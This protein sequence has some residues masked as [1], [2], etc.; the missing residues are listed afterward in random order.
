MM[1]TRFDVYLLGD[2]QPGLA[3]SQVIRNLAQV[4]KREP[5]HI[6]AMLARPRSLVKRG[7]DD[8]RARQYQRVITEAGGL[9]DLVAVAPE[10]SLEPIVEPSAG[11]LIT[12]ATAAPS[13]IG[14]PYAAPAAATADT[15]YCSRCGSAL[16]VGVLACPR[17]GTRQQEYVSKDKVVAGVLAFFVGGLGV[18]RFY[19]GQW[20]G[21]FYLIFW[22]TLIPSIISLIEAFVFWLTPRETWE[23]KYGQVPKSGVGLVAGIAI[24]V[25]AF[26]MV[27]G[28][29]AAIAL[30]AY[31]DYTQRAR[32]SA[33]APVISQARQQIE[34]FTRREGRFPS[35]AGELS[36]PPPPSDSH[37]KRLE[38]GA[39]G[40]LV[41]TYEVL[42]ADSTIIWVPERSGE[43]FTW[44]CTG[45]TVVN[46]YRSPECRDATQA[47]SQSTVKRLYSNDRRISLEVPNS[48]RQNNSLNE[49]ASLGAANLLQEG[50]VIV[51]EDSFVDFDEPPTLDEYADLI[52]G[53]MSGNI[54]NPRF[55]S[56]L[57]PMVIDGWPAYQR[58]LQ[59]SVDNI[60]ITYLITLVEREDAFYQIIGWSL[61]SRFSDKY[62]ELRTVSRSLRVQ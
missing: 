47:A 27:S 18:H 41:A 5:A 29:L 2:V 21:I 54:D 20:W 10:L 22:A 25:M 49:D 23:R 62:A 61:S 15:R 24:A 8:A 9:C 6:E 40:Q 33:S 53:T 30:P 4:F 31:Q 39:D 11:P 58:V 32:I 7:V 34:S 45:G 57:N 26:I 13:P 50:Y 48:W 3:R 1:E 28:I 55:A 36:L 17:C 19:L 60:K 42:G 16:V 35:G 52:L 38:L 51:I 12:P 46:R 59:G 56:D 43:L 14:S 37:L 44:S